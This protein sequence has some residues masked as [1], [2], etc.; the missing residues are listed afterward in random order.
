MLANRLRKN[1]KALNNWLKQRNIGCYRLYDADLPEYALAIDIYTSADHD[2]AG[3]VFAHVQEYA[4]PADVDPR[5]ARRRL[6][7][8]M[9]VIMETLE[10]PRERLF[11]KVRQR[12]RGAAQYERQGEGGQFI[13]VREAGLRLLVNLTDY[14]DTGLFLDHRQTRALIGERA[15]GRR[16]LN[17]FGYTG[18]A[19]VHAAAG[20][21][22]AT[23]TVDLSRT[24]CD[25]AGRNLA[26]N[27]FATAAHRIEQADCLQWLE[28]P[29]WEKF[30]LIFLDPP[31]FS[32]SKRMRGSFDIQRDHVSL[33]THAARLLEPD[34]E[35][36]FSTN[37]RRFKLDT[38]SLS[39][40]D[41]AL[42]I[43]DLKAR[44]LPRDFQRRASIHHCWRLRRRH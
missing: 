36:I 30:G 24:Y 28:R 40:S 6:R 15:H 35:L 10:L 23:L 20:G 33:I 26:L 18:A 4:A 16:F 44:T 32:T 37:L 39:A 34:G 7:E 3:Q 13:E 31:S 41:L 5:A 11:F 21:A 9:G 22:H 8:A 19:S 42:E 1:R 43:E 27:G 14:L 17:L 12:Q 38:E 2:A 25:W 29:R